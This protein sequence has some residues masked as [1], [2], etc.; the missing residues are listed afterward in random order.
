MSSF[1]LVEGVQYIQISAPIDHGSSG[2]GLFNKKGELVGITTSGYTSNADLNFAVAIDEASNW[3]RYFSVSFKDIAVLPPE[4]ITNP[5]VFGDIALGMTKNQVKHLETG[6]LL[7]EKSDSLFYRDIWV[8]DYHSEVIY[9]FENNKLVAINIYHTVVDNLYDLDLLE[10]YFK[11][12]LDNLIYI[13]GKPYFLDTNW[14]DDSD[15]YT[16]SAYWSSNGHDTLLVTK[17]TVEYSTYGGI[18]ISINE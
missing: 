10:T 13:Y 3:Y 6:T 9:E 11:L 5:P 15:G 2:G 4:V 14:F 8:F 7:N 1:R 18:R 16:L 12:M 17:V